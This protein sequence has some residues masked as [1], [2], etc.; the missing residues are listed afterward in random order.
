M[1][2][3]LSEGVVAELAVPIRTEEQIEGV[4][5]VDN[6]SSRPFT[7]R[8]ERTLQRLADHAAIAIRNARL[9]AMA[10]QRAQQLETL[11]TVGAGAD[12]GAGPA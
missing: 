10:V 12:D 2:I 9:H 1:P 8:D 6:R 3:T 5:F 4:L 7:D 11:H